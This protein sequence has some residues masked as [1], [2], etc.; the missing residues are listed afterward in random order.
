MSTVVLSPA[1][2]QPGRE[3]EPLTLSC[4]VA[5]N[6]KIQ[7][8]CQCLP[9]WLGNGQIYIHITTLYLDNHFEIYFPKTLFS[10]FYQCFGQFAGTPL[11]S[12]TCPLSFIVTNDKEH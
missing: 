7:I 2:D 1:V 9:S 3:A 6:E 4:A 10:A 11:A 12:V 5:N 8:Y